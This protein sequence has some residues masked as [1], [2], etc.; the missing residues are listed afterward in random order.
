MKRT[1][2]ELP[3][4]ALLVGTVV[5]SGCSSNSAAATTQ[6]MNVTVKVSQAQKGLIGK[7]EIYTGTVTPSET[8]NIIPKMGGKVVS[9]PVDIGTEVKKGQVLLKLEDND[10]RNNLA[11][12]QADVAA[13]GA[14]VKTAQ[15][16]QQ[17][18]MVS[19]NSGVVSSK[20]GIISSKS[21]I[22]QATGSINQANGA[23]N[24]ATTAVEQAKTAVSSAANNIKQTTETLSAA[25]KTLTRT[26]SL[27][28]N[29]L[30]TQAQLEQAQTAQ[31][32]AQ[33]AN[34]NAKNAQV[35]AQEQLNAAQK[36]L[37]IAKKNL[38]TAQSA[39]Q[40]ATSSYENANSGYSNA[41]KQLEVSQSTSG[42]EASQQKQK[43]AELNV[44]IAQ[45]ALDDA[46][47][48]SPINGIIGTK[49]TEVG[50]MA[51]TSSPALV[52]ANLSTVNTLIYVPADQI[53]NVKIGDPVQV[54]VTS[55][56]ILK[57]GKVKN[58]SPL[59]DSGKG[60]PVKIAVSNADNKLKSG[61]LA[62]ISF[63][64]ASAKEGIIVPFKAIQ[65]IDGKSYVY[66]VQ[67]NIAIRKQVTLGKATGSQV[68]IN[69]GLNDGD[70]VITNNLALLEDK[71]PITV[72]Q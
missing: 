36:A 67:K 25:Q 37:V 35:N 34:D 30:A 9:L 22:D 46:V 31:A 32:T 12:A 20:N 42:I 17:S 26:Q 44:N 23:I 59:D 72:S 1:K 15:D 21:A 58:I 10:L 47:V 19:A 18:G 39:Y 61:M 70:T 5:L 53:N 57:T 40:N 56:N 55:S 33:T 69:S 24:Q 3:L 50:E 64:D 28:Q 68:F 45:D 49:N 66:V 65:T 41:Q 63:V 29:G 11:K 13:A 6:A 38:S 43:Q 71:N 60:Y 54:R 48:T 27:F 51:S 14:A 16:S 8:V 52:I 2:W 62:D 4:A 7:G